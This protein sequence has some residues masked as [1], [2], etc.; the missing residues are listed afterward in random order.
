MALLHFLSLK[1]RVTAAFF[2]HG[3]K[4]SE[5]ALEFLIPMCEKMGVELQVGH[6]KHAKGKGVSDE[7][8]WRNCRYEYLEKFPLVAT[9]HHLGDVAETWVWSCLHGTPKLIPYSRGNVIRPLLAETKENLIEWCKSRNIDWCK[10]DSNDDIMYTRN[11]IRHQ[12]M[13]DVLRV[14]PGINKMLRKKIIE[15]FTTQDH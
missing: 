10:D 15:R 7:E 2:H 11:F 8:H 13:P 9:A 3:T 6:I 14:N 12:M 5:A 4:N 1:H